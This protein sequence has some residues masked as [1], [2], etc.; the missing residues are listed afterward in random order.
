MKTL[1]VLGIYEY[2]NKRDIIGIEVDNNERL[3]VNVNDKLFEEY[4]DKI[5]QPQ[6]EYVIDAVTNIVK[7]KSNKFNNESQKVL[8]REIFYLTTK[9]KWYVIKSIKHANIKSVERKTQLDDNVESIKEYKK[10]NISFKDVVGMDD[11]KEKLNDVIHQFNNRELYKEWNIKP[12]KGVLLY[13]PTGTGKSFISEALANEIDATFIK[14]SAGDIMS[15]YI[16]ES[17]RNIKKLFENARKNTFS[18]IYIDEI[19]FVASKREEGDNGKERNATLN[20]LLVQMASAE[21]DNIFMIFATNMMELLDPAFLRSGRCDFKIEV[22]LPDFSCRK[23]IL[24]ICSKGRPIAPDVDFEKISRNASGMNCADMTQL[25]NESARKALKNGKSMIEKIDFDDTFE[26][27]ICGACSKTKKI[28]ENEKYTVAVH[29]IGHYMANEFYKSKKTKKISILPRGS[30]L[31]FVL[32]ANEENDDKYLYTEEELLNDIRI[33]LAGRAAEQ[34]IFRRVT[35]GSSNDLEKATKTARN[36]ICKYG[37]NEETGLV[38]LDKHNPMLSNMINKQAKYI[39][40]RCYDEMLTVL[41]A[42][43]E[44]LVS[45]ANILKDK[46]ELSGDEIKDITDGVI[47][48]I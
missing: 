24:E 5:H 44:V 16:G 41:E 42:N 38:V 26:E 46:E 32:Y 47:L 40:D 2:G 10:S 20:E 7:L 30:A 36:L 34:V 1:Y 29:E 35:T 11:V 8:D 22:P 14:A 43:R 31:G 25:A 19:D 3:V 9:C 6:Q 27:L 45:L 4:L 17:G 39:L 37:F 12:I 15:K 33:S 23:G 28:D 48:G 18:I 13:G 21:N